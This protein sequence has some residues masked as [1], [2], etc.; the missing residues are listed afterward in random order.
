[1]FSVTSE[2]RCWLFAYHVKRK[3][4]GGEGVGVCF[5][6]GFSTDHTKH[7]QI[8]SVVEWE[9]EGLALEESCVEGGRTVK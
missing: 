7:K 3:K 4:K 2:K 8:L 9:W 5:F 1:M 6:Q